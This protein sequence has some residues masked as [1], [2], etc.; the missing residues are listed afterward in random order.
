M[1]Q[2]VANQGLLLNVIYSI[3]WKF[4]QPSAAEWNRTKSFFFNFSAP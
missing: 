2:V 3:E 4:I 1:K